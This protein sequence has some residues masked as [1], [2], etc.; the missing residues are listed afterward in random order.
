MDILKKQGLISETLPSLY[1]ENDQE[2]GEDLT[3]Q[4]LSFPVSRTLRLQA[5]ARGTKGSCLDRPIHCSGG[6]AW[7]GTRFLES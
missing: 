3:R 4:P 2:T 6:S 7:T 5:L 1:P